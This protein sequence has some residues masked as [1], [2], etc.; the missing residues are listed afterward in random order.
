MLVENPRVRTSLRQRGN[1]TARF[2]LADGV[3]E[4]LMMDAALVEDP[5]LRCRH[6]DPPVFIH[7]RLKS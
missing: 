6:P 2:R 1:E 3:I 5:V 4:I 7:S